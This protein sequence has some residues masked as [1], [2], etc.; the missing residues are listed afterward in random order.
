LKIKLIC[1]LCSKEFKVLSYRKNT[2]KFCSNI[3]KYKYPKG[4]KHSKEWSNKISQSLKGKSLSKEHKKRISLGQ[5]RRFKDPKNHPMWKGGISFAPYPLEWT[6]EYKENVRFR[7]GYEC[8]ICSIQQ[9]WGSEKLH[10][11]HI[12]YDKNN[13]NLYNLIALCR[14]CHMKTNANREYWIRFFLIFPNKALIKLQQ[15]KDLF[16]KKSP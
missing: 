5:K 2:A 10:I 4:R 7:D 1:L 15:R 12:D 8:Q 11:H 6:W 14:S 13:L 9:E 3:C 16:L